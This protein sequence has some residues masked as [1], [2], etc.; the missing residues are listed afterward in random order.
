MRWIP[1]MRCQAQRGQA[2]RI[3]EDPDRPH[4]RRWV[5]VSGPNLEVRPKD[6]QPDYGDAFTR[7]NAER[8]SK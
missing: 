3:V 2:W 1:G 7:D 4:G 5:H 6:P 8:G